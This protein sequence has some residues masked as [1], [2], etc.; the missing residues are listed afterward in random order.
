MI[1]AE[2][3]SIEARI[4]A[5]SLCT[6]YGKTYCYE[7]CFRD[8]FVENFSDAKALIA[9]VKR[10]TRERD[11]AVQDFQNYITGNFTRTCQLCAKIKTCDYFSR[12]GNS[13]YMT[14]I[15][16]QWR[17]IQGADNA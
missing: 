2:L 11:E 3:E 16:W 7:E 13:S 5:I 4:K 12:Y 14:C 8:C 17:G 1:P 15:D 9:E 10:L 6:G